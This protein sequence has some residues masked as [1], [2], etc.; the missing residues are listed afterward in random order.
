MAEVSV[1][2]T[3]RRAFFLTRYPIS[4]IATFEGI[5]HLFI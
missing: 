3:G 1:L 5:W 4:L 2:L